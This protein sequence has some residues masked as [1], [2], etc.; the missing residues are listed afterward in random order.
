MMIATGFSPILASLSNDIGRELILDEGD[1][2]AQLQFSLLEALHLEQVG[3]RRTLERADRRVEV[4]MLL[5]QTCQSRPE[6]AFFL[7]GHRRR[8]VAGRA[9]P[10]CM[11]RKPNKYR[12]SACLLQVE[13][14]NLLTAWGDLLRCTMNALWT[15]AGARGKIMRSNWQRGARRK[16][17]CPCNRIL[18]NWKDGTGRSR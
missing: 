17:A 7:F 15:N 18:G 11:H 16:T 12:V 6:L 9:Q 10:A 8:F 2:I 13:R 1:T 3:T 4:A 5:L 14:P